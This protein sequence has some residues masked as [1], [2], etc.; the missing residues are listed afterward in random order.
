MRVSCPS[1]VATA[2]CSL[3]VAQLRLVGH[4]LL[5]LLERL[6]VG[7]EL[8][9]EPAPTRGPRRCVSSRV[10]GGAES[11]GPAV[12]R[13]GGI[14]RDGVGARDGLQVLVELVHEGD[15]CGQ[16][17]ADR[18]RQTSIVGASTGEA[19]RP[20]RCPTRRRRRPPG[21]VGAAS[22]LEATRRVDGAFPVRGGAALF[23]RRRGPSGSR[24]S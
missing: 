24:A 4:L 7:E 3:R 5:R 18:T 11:A 12:E 19:T 14:R 8:A 16:H 2:R 10:L 22:V 17:T 9:G 1:H 23:S 13:R 6:G 20:R 15:A 21:C